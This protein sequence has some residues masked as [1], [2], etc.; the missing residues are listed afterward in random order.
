[1]PDNIHALWDLIP[2]AGPA[3]Q[4][5]SARYLVEGS[6]HYMDFGTLPTF[7]AP[8]PA[9]LHFSYVVRCFGS[10]AIKNVDYN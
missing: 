4:K 3:R 2:S 7:S 9:P 5:C 8:L 6:N 1:M 10:A